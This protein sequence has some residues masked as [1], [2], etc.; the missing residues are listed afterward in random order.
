MSGLLKLLGTIVVLLLLVRA[1]T[2]EPAEVR[3]R[4][5]IT[6]DD[7]GTTR[8]GSAVWAQ[9]FHRALPAEAAHSFQA[10][11]IPIELPGRATLFAMPIGRDEDGS[12]AGTLEWLALQLFSRE[13]GLPGRDF[14]R[15]LAKNVGASRT[16][17]CRAFPMYGPRCPYLVVFGDRS[18]PTT[19]RAVDLLGLSD[20][21]EGVTLREVRVE[22]TDEPLTRNLHQWLPWVDQPEPNCRGDQDCLLRRDFRIR[23]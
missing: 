22:I 15:D 18:D 7:N 12:A 17:D 1:C 9:R 5:V 6:V 8:S 14:A 19:M 16:A 23:H 3:F 4:V 11:A 13:P 10:D 20:T 21:F 2:Q